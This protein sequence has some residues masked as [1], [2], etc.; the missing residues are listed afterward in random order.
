[1]QQR[2]LENLG[3]QLMESTGSQCNAF[4]GVDSCVAL[5]GDT[6]FASRCPDHPLLVRTKDCPRIRAADGFFPSV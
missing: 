6:V 1:M 3:A 2:V 4:G 5:P